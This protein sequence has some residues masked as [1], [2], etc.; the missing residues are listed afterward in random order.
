VV[1]GLAGVLG[2]RTGAAHGAICGRLLP[3]ALELNAARVAPDGETARRLAEIR[4]LIAA[5][6]GSEAR[7]APAAL[8]GWSAAHGLPGLA[9]MGLAAA[10]AAETAEASAASSSMKGN[11][12]ALGADDLAALLS[13][14]L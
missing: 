5:A 14:A 12:V 11:P 1:H 7:D 9:G 4:G 8:A 13:R 2:G 6:L 10:A 3:F